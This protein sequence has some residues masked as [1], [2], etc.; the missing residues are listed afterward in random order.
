MHKNINNI[1][2]NKQ[3][4]VFGIFMNTLS[5]IKKG[6]ITKNKRVGIDFTKSPPHANKDHS[7]SSKPNYYHQLTKI[8][9]HRWK[10]Y[11]PL[12]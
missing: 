6:K 11:K 2:I 10:E 12:D 9:K 8:L 7:S 4:L 5:V 1:S 3:K